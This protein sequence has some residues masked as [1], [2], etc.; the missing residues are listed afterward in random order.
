MIKQKKLEM[1]E[2]T[3]NTRSVAELESD[4]T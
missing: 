4:L 3:A 2:N 1:L